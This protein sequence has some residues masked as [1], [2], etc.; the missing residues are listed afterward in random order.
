VELQDVFKRRRMIRSF[1]PDPIDP[2]V[3]DEILASVLH[4]PSAGF[5]QGNEFL[6]ISDPAQVATFFELAE[7]PSFPTPERYLAVRPPVIVLVLSNASVY[8]ER[9]SAPDKIQFGLDKVENWP[10]PYWDVDAGMASMLLLL[11]VIEHGLGAYFAG[12]SHGERDVFEHFGIP[13]GF[14]TVGLI[15]LGYPTAVDDASATASA[16]SRHRRPLAE[17]VHHDRW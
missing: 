13:D 6:V 9:Y 4:A 11:A 7:D 2:A 1:R 8:T 10:V 14:R 16:F 17:I 12:L 5:S 15:G 3:V